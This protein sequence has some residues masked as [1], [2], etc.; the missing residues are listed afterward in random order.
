MRDIRL[1]GVIPAA[2]C[3]FHPDLSLDEN[4][5]RRHVRFLVQTPGVSGVCVNGHAGE[6][7]SLTPEEQVRVI[8]LAKNE[9]GSIPII[10]GIYA[11]ST[12]E[13]CDLAKAAAGAGADALLV[14]PPPLFSWGATR[15]DRVPVAYVQTL[16]AVAELPLVIFQY[17]PASG[18][19][20]TPETLRRLAE[21]PSV[22]AV[23]E[24]TGEMKRYEQNVRLLRSLARPVAVLTS[25]NDWL[26]ASLCVGADGILSGSGSL[27]PS[28][29]AELFEAVSRGDLEAAR[30]VNDRIFTLSQAFY[31]DPP[32]DMHTRMKAASVLLGRFDCPLP[33]P[34]LL[35][36]GPEETERIAAALV[37]VGLLR[38]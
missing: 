2:L 32:L 8:R 9:A 35:P 19:G 20:Y 4:G 18:L 34:L 33:R 24:G 10:A 16:A 37:A 36:I 38:R 28:W 29:H 11:Q 7:A 21:M 30:K 12:R 14:F 6:V 5:L 23:K 27:I 13:A 15:T 3:P 25:N 17:P 26:F 22:I 31:A 1:A